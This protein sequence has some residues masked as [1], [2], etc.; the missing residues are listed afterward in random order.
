MFQEKKSVEQEK[1]EVLMSVNSNSSEL[2]DEGYSSFLQ[3][4]KNET[5]S[6][7]TEVSKFRIS[8]CI[9]NGKAS[10]IE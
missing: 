3:E 7:H 6:D 2:R 1:V 5:A 10:Q 9:P 4:L 8:Y